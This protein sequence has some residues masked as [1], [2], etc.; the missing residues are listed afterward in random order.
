MSVALN[1][2]TSRSLVIIDEFGKGTSETNGLSLLLA[3]LSDF[4]HR[5]YN[6]MPHVIISTHFYSLPNLL[7][8][9]I[10]KDVYHNIKVSTYDIFKCL[11]TYLVKNKMIGYYNTSY[12]NILFFSI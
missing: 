8:Q 3:S 6:L 10:H 4:L 11:D 2:S 1:E 7:Q 5:P 12:K 9:I